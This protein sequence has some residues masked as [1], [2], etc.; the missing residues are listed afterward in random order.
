[1]R[2]LVKL[3]GVYAKLFLS[4][5]SLLLVTT[6]AV[7][8]T[9]YLIFTSSLNEEVEKVHS[10]LL[11]HTSEQIQDNLLERA[12]KVFADMVTNPDVHYLFDNPIQGN[13]SKVMDIYQ[14][15]KATVALYPNLV[16]SISV[17]YRGSNAVISSNYGLALLDSLP[18]KITIST[19]WIER[20]NRAETGS[21]W[22]ET[23]TVP[24]SANSST[25]TAKVVSY[26]GGYPY[27]STGTKAKG[28]IA[29]NL[30]ADAF[31]QM[32]RS[33]DQSDRGQMWITDDAGHM[34]ALGNTD[35]SISMEDNA[36]L[37]ALMKDSDKGKFGETVGGL[38]SLVS[39]VKI[40]YSGWLL[41]QAS[42]TDEYNRKAVVVQRTLI[43]I[44]L[45]A[46]GLGL[47]FSKVLTSNMY[48][49]LKSLLQTVKSLFNPPLPPG[50]KHENE[51]KQI[52][53]FVAD[54][55]VRMS[56]L[57]A[58]VADN[59]PIIRHNLV[60]GLLNRTITQQ[61][62]LTDRLRFL[63][64]DWAE[65]SYCVL[66]IR[67]DERD[68]GRLLEENRQTVVYSLIRELEAARTADVAF[69]A[70]SVSANDIAAVVHSPYRDE[71][72]V[73]L[74]A[75]ALSAL[76]YEQFQVRLSASTGGWVEEPL[77]LYRSFREAQ[78]GLERRFFRP[79]TLV[80]LHSELA[81]PEAGTEPIPPSVQEA[82]LESL[83]GRSLEPLKEA[84]AEL[85]RLL[86]SDRYTVSYSHEQWRQWVGM[87]HQY[88][89]DMHLKTVDVL[90]ERLAAQER[91]ISDIH[92]F[93][94][95]LLQAAEV[96]F[97]Y[98]EGR[99]RNKAGDAVAIIKSYIEANL[100]GDLSLQAAADSVSLHPRYVSQLFKEETGINFVD[101][102]NRRRIETAARLLI[103][104]DLNVEQIAAQVGFNTPAY[105]IKKFKEAY[106]V[107]PRTYKFNY[108]T[109]K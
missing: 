6:L 26:V 3:R 46:I 9:S 24:I 85:V 108:T 56:G 106:G 88:L 2:L 58:T 31:Y 22:M 68:M 5:A 95:W 103:A 72:L 99:A 33:T 38:A 86:G 43:L 40:P 66:L 25:F 37:V 62:E 42:P 63:R 61:A 76:A 105:F 91:A 47:I 7:G 53:H 8:M 107:T 82:Y 4:Y 80:F 44:C 30:H 20:M 81:G 16:E 15:L 89:K 11:S 69:T 18:D 67:L 104:S 1:M 10:H 32:I 29:V 78:A 87:F 97:L 41:V 54:M 92:E 100:A 36:K 14:Y 65:S 48:M 101:Y 35:T 71:P 109:N 57:E 94:A 60:F 59:M 34:I 90:G 28:F 45:A 51:Y 19:D 55:S 13:N 98:L 21:L 27:H 75:E 96:T 23:R 52:N 84:V 83:K 102:V 73:R 39:Y 70:I 49:P 93:Q 77:Q 64:L 50:G 79:G 17:Y 12:G 74:A